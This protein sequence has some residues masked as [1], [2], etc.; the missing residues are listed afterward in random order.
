MA[1]VVYS[2]ERKMEKPGDTLDEEAALVVKERLPFVGRGG[3]KLQEALNRFAFD[4]KGKVVADIGSSTGGFTDCLI[5]N[6]VEKV[7]AVDVDTRQLDWRLR[8]HPRVTLVEK[9]ARYLSQD[10]F[11]DVPDMATLDVSFISLLKILP[12]ISRMK[13]FVSLL[14]L[15]KPQFEAGRRDV[16]RKG[17]VREASVHKAVLKR[18]VDG[19]EE[20]GFYPRGLIR[21][22]TRG[23]KGNVEFF[24]FFS[25][26]KPVGHRASVGDW[27]DEA[28]RDE[29]N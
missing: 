27:I 21:S 8:R 11:G 19:A 24:I 6:G 22:S 4:V 23:Q 18:T 16:G 10:D 20:M 1:G 7:Y 12:A 15:V 28:V 9:N 2:G 14:A 5:Q 17:V 3:L 13:G 29:K 25:R 26:E